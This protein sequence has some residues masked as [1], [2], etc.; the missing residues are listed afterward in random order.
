MGKFYI[1]TPIYYVNDEPHIGHAYTTVMADVLARYHRTA[2]DDVMFL[3]GTDEHGQK[4]E[5]AAQSRGVSPQEHCDE[6]VRRFKDLWEKLEI[7]NDDFIRTTESR[8]K[9]VVQ[10]I[11]QRLFDAGEIYADNYEGWYCVPDER[12]WTEKDLVAGNCPDCGRTVVQI[13]EKNYFFR[14]STYQDWLVKHIQ[15]HPGFIQPETR[16]NE[17]LG[18]LRKP[19]NDLCISR[20]RARLK[21][22][23]PLPFDEAYVCYVWFDA[24]INYVT[25]PGYLADEGTFEKWWPASCHLIG[26]DI[27]TTHCVYW[28]TMLKAIGVP[29]PETVLGHGWWM[30]D[31]EKMSKSR[32]NVIRPLDLAEKYGVDAFRYFLVREMVL[33]LDSSFSEAAFVQRYNAE[34]ANELG[35]LLNRSVVMAQRYLKG[36]IPEA[37][38][39]HPVLRDLQAQARA[40]VDEATT[41]LNQLNPNGVLDAAWKLVREAN[42]FVEV[43]APWN[44]V[45][46][47]ERR[48]DLNAT[49]YGLLETMRQLAVLLFPVMPG[50]AREIWRQIGAGG[51]LESVHLDDLNPWGRL[52]AGLHVASG[53]P[54]FPRLEAI[55]LEE[56]TPKDPEP[57][58]PQMA[59]AQTELVSFSDFQKLKLRVAQIEA[60]ERVAGADRLLKLQVSLGE[61]K[62]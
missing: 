48:S 42:R 1:T 47:P 57:E 58:E 55:T 51:D 62:R 7:S 49:I 34:L 22:G 18:F 33:G 31:E 43:Q 37:D 26:K 28:P 32:G 29:M 24:L 27:L 10:S 6:M 60:A 9:Q 46:D 50:K 59:E 52:P 2:G 11:L 38:R 21:W 16:R 41:S 12:F 54:V 61:E 17:I 25:A 14:M 40:T 3:T 53:S 23:I 20:P 4:V 35:N 19:L 30:V 39:A 15:S 44:L 5:Q 56:D 45:K 8:H 36:I 13:S